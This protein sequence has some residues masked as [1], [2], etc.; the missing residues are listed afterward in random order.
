VIAAPSHVLA[1]ALLAA[2]PTASL[3][4]AGGLSQGTYALAGDRLEV[5]LRFSA[6]ELAAGWPGLAA[7]PE[8][9]GDGVPGA[10]AAA[11]A[12]AVAVAQESGACA[13]AGASGRPEPPDGA[14]LSASFRCPRPGEAVRVQLGFLGRLPPGH[15]HLARTASAEAAQ[16]HVADARDAELTVEGRGAWVPV[17]R[18]V[19]LG[20]EHILTG[21]DHVAFLVGLLL[22]GGGLGALA[23]TV[24]A[25][26]VGHAVTLALATV[27]AVRPP[28][29]LVE[30]LI[31][32]SVV[33]V[34]VDN[35]WALRRGA[36]GPGRRWPIALA[37]GLVHGFGFAGALAELGLPRAGLAA[38]LASFNVGVEL[39]QAALVTAL[40]PLLA[41]L[42]QRPL[43]ARPLLPAAS[44]LV[45]CAGL[46]W[47]AQRLAG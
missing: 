42:R 36:A 12:G 16:Q 2:L 20:V 38:A 41:L 1:A 4:H 10:L 44:T 40:F 21:W 30:P 31:A 43:L 9:L 26:T 46:A 39:G 37:F 25:F 22:A 8:R 33:A 35:L 27:G 47:L 13:L 18:Y 23:R 3:A 32:A 24:T 15:V 28:S 34:A 45:G 14:R 11:I 17:T 6:A 5:T 7:P 19:A 29:S